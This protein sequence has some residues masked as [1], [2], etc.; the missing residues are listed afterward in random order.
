[1]DKQLVISFKENDEEAIIEDKEECID[2]EK[3]DGKSILY[4]NRVKKLVKEISIKEDLS[5]I[6]LGEEGTSRLEEINKLLLSIIIFDV[7]EELKKDNKKQ[8][9]PKH[10]DKAL[11]NLLNGAS[12]I[13]IALNILNKD[14]E[15]LKGLNNSTSINKATMFV[16]E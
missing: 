1:M 13:D 15:T 8:I 7:L 10:L 12:A 5:N 6:Q 2:D 4:K 9:K 11:D 14:I 3:D 16:N